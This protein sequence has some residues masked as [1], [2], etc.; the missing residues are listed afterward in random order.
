VI[1]GRAGSTTDYRFKQPD[2]LMP[3]I[4]VDGGL[5]TK[6]DAQHPG[7]ALSFPDQWELS[8]GAPLRM[9]AVFPPGEGWKTI[10]VTLTW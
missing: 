10:T 3:R 9:H 6:A 2:R 4:E 8:H 5:S 1:E 7:V